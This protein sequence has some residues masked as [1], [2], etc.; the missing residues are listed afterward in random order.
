MMRA[1]IAPPALRIIVQLHVPRDP[2]AVILAALRA[3]ATKLT[4]GIADDVIE[5]DD[6]APDNAYSLTVHLYPK[7]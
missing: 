7:E 2:D 3:T 1:P 6:A 4:V 5:R